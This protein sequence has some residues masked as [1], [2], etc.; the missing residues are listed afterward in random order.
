[1]DYADIYSPDLLVMM[2]GALLLTGIFAGLLAGLLGVGG[3]IVIVPV[4]FVLFSYMG[5]PTE[6]IMHMA[7]ATSL[8]TIIPISLLS[9]RSH[10]RRGAVDFVILGQWGPFM[11]AGAAVGGGLS[12]F[13]DS[14]YLQ[15]LF[16]VI[17]LYVAVTMIRGQP[18]QKPPEPAP[19]DATDRPHPLTPLG[20]GGTGG[21]I[22]SVIGLASA[23]MGIGG[24]T[25][26]VPILSYLSLPMHRA[27]GT[28]AAFG[29]L[30]AVPG[31]IGFGWAGTSVELRPPY[32]LG[33]VSVP[34]AIIIFSTSLFTVPLGSRIAH[35]LNAAVLR[36]IFGGFLLLSALNIL[37]G[38]FGL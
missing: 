6:F 36:R 28:A 27:V 8:M 3:G 38:V 30:I 33:F 34:A 23:L 32:S 19:T 17:A 35:L 1:L 14:R 2:A 31:A 37:R 25:I 13:L 22:S 10:H 20:R 5:V 12:G 11:L 7:V 9:A 26:A 15:L 29:I 24:G 4:L 18:P 21:L 16:G